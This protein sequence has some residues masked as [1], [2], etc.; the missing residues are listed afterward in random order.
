MIDIVVLAWQP[1]NIRMEVL[2]YYEITL[3]AMLVLLLPIVNLI[4]KQMNIRL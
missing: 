1:S 4:L 2:G 3:Y